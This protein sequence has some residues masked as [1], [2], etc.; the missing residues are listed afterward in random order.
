MALTMLEQLSM[1]LAT[2]PL[3]ITSFMVAKASLVLAV[4]RP[5]TKPKRPVVMA[6][7]VAVGTKPLGLSPKHSCLLTRRLKPR[8]V[9]FTKTLTAGLTVMKKVI[10]KPPRLML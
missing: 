9:G 1:A 6:F 7:V 8:L 3:L 2:S 4:T 10:T 5:L